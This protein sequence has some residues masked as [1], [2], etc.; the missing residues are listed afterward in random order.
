MGQKVASKEIAFLAG[1]RRPLLPD[2]AH[3]LEHRMIGSLPVVEQT[4]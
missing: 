3:A 2:Y 1:L 4:L